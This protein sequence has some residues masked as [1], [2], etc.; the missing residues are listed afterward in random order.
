[1]I[2]KVISATKL[3]RVKNIEV[4]V[5]LVYASLELGYRVVVVVSFRSGSVH[6]ADTVSFSPEIP[7]ICQ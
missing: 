3:F 2:N 4:V 1:M 5:E 6:H 7:R